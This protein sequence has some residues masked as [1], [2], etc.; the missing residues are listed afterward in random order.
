[1]KVPYI[2]LLIRCAPANSR[3][4]ESAA[5]KSGDI[6]GRPI[7]SAGDGRTPHSWLSY[8]TEN[9]SNCGSSKLSDWE[10]PTRVLD[11]AGSSWADLR[12]FITHG[13]CGKY[14]TLSHRWGGSKIIKTTLSNLEAHTRC[15]PFSDLNKTFQ[16]AVV[17]TRKLGFR[18]LWIDSLCIIQDSKDDWRREAGW[19]ASIYSG[20][21][22]T[23]SA[24]WATSGDSG[25]FY[26]RPECRKVEFPYINVNG[27]AEGRWF[28]RKRSAALFSSDV[29]EGPLNSRGWVLQERLLSNRTLH[30]CKD[31]LYWECKSSVWKECTG[32]MNDGLATYP[33]ALFRNNIFRTRIGTTQPS[34]TISADAGVEHLCEGWYKLVEDYTNRS[35]SVIQDRLP[36][37]L[38]IANTLR[39][40]YSGRYIWGLWES[41]LLR[42]LLW[43]IDTKDIA[44]KRLVSPSWSW[45]AW[46]A[47]IHFRLP[48]GPKLLG[49]AVV[50]NIEEQLITKRLGHNSPKTCI[51]IRGPLLKIPAIKPLKG[52]STNSLLFDSQRRYMGA[53]CLD[54][55][56]SLPIPWRDMWVLMLYSDDP[57]SPTPLKASEAE[58]PHTYCLVLEK[59]HMDTYRRIGYAETSTNEFDDAPTQLVV[60]T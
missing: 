43:S 19:M 55:P 3:C 17:I 29:L 26:P 44:Y 53:A 57:I 58:A 50:A 22:L 54:S 11:V 18:Y 48:W 60:I 56:L 24:T 25:L 12:L 14:L 45:A 52:S 21:E 32:I 9:H 38:G 42:G 28:M 6:A 30:F 36:A 49:K 23:L 51:R 46:S 35:L 15:I 1:M 59:R 8:C 2:S 47:P 10:L 37:V 33:V 20:S 41:G 5:A 34:G 40:S 16:D 13:A 4:T 31:Q 27:H 7:Y 39:C